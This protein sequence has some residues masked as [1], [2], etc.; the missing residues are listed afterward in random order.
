MWSLISCLGKAQL[1][2]L[3]VLHFG[4]LELGYSTGNKLH[5]LT[6]GEGGI[7]RLAQFHLAEGV[8]EG[9]IQGVQDDGLIYTYCGMIT[10]VR[11]VNIS[12]SE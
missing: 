2:L 10:T 12:Y 6:L 5:L 9:F 1:P 8:H 4:V 3:M 11:V 7:Y